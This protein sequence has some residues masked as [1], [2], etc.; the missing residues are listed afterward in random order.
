MDHRVA[1]EFAILFRSALPRGERSRHFGVQIRDV[2]GFDP[3]SRAGSD[4]EVANALDVGQSF[5]SALPRGERFS[6]NLGVAPQYTFRSALPR[7][8]R[9]S[10][11][12]QA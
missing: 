9:S 2:V 10:A 4:D 3:R 1:F 8:E 6:N 5:R 7:G 11:S 12:T